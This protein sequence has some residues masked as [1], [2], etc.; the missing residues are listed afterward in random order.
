MNAKRPIKVKL[1]NHAEGVVAHAT[2]TKWTKHFAMHN[3]LE[4]CFV[5]VVT[6]RP[7]GFAVCRGND[8][9]LVEAVLD[10]IATTDEKDIADFNAAVVKWTAEGRD[11]T[12]FREG[13]GATPFGKSVTKFMKDYKTRAAKELAKRVK[14][15]KNALVKAQVALEALSVPKNSTMSERLQAAIVALKKSGDP[16]GSALDEYEEALTAYDKEARRLF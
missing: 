1:S 15:K 5:S 14:S 2:S 7:S 3:A 16:L 6:H 4:D 8:A 12:S 10:Y 11:E 9:A 13:A